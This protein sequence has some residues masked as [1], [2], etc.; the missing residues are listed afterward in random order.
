MTSTPDRV[1]S[2]RVALVTGSVGGGIGRSTA[3]RLARAGANIVLSYGSSGR[4]IDRT[5]EVARITEAI[6][7]FGSRSIAV[8]ADT[9]TRD[10]VA[11]LIAQAQEAF[12]DI[13]ILVNNA[14]APWLEEDFT[15]TSF[16]RW[17]DTLALEVIGPAQIIAAVLPAMRG[18][19]WGRI[20][21]IVIDFRTFEFLLDANYVHRLDRAPYP[22]WIAKHARLE[23]VEQL[24][25]AELRHGVT[26]NAVLPGIIEECSWDT[27]VVAASQDPAET[28]L[29]AGPDHVARMVVRL[30]S[31][32]FRWV[33]GSR[34]IMP[35][36]LYE[37]IR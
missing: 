18:N 34:I 8:A 6:A 2:G 30:C 25:H 24:A 35:G 29:L 11:T 17:R 27:A 28:A 22:F 16:E 36:N 37:R 4:A 1:L 14:G 32:E 9:R 31:D 13:D 20:V 3:L 15:A 10:G 5:A 7:S 19:R 33:T 23:I 26:V 12:G 21:N